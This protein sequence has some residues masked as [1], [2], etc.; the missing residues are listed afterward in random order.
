MYFFPIDKLALKIKWNFQQKTDVPPH[1]ILHF[2]NTL[3]EFIVRDGRPGIITCE[4]AEPEELIDINGILVEI[5]MAIDDQGGWS[6]LH[7]SV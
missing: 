4:L 6:P 1:S 2:A 7:F 5:K 3:P